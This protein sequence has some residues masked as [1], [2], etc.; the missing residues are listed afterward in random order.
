MNNICAAGI[1]L[2]KTVLF[3][4][5]MSPRMETVLRLGLDFT[6]TDVCLLGTFFRSLIYTC[7]DP[8]IWTFRTHTTL[9]PCKFITGILLTSAIPFQACFTTISFHMSCMFFI[10]GIF[11]FSQKWDKWKTQ[12]NT[13][14]VGSLILCLASSGTANVS[15][16]D[17]SA[18]VKLFWPVI[19]KYIIVGLHVI[20]M[21]HNTH[22]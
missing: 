10:S 3:F 15:L 20:K 18:G 2:F 5:K 1:P 16:C 21:M 7:S 13:S 22:I 19:T 12:W 14:S 11:C 8:G 17:L 4:V 6:T 9:F